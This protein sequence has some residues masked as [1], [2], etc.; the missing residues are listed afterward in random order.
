MFFYKKTNY[1]FLSRNCK[2][3]VQKPISHKIHFIEFLHQKLMILIVHKELFSKWKKQKNKKWKNIITEALNIL[4]FWL[5][6]GIPFIRLS[7]ELALQCAMLTLFL[8]DSSLLF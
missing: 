7:E 1:I 6:I 5:K 3:V 2:S 8:V 4:A